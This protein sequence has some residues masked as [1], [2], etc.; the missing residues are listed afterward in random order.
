MVLLNRRLHMPHIPGA[1]KS[2]QNPIRWHLMTMGNAL[3][4]SCT[5]PAM[6]R[7]TI[8]HNWQCEPDSLPYYYF[9]PLLSETSGHSGTHHLDRC[10]ILESEAPVALVH[11]PRVEDHISP[12]LR[13]LLNRMRG[14]TYEP[15]SPNM[16]L[17][18]S[19]QR[20]Q[21]H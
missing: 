11:P 16:G 4:H 7:A 12:A 3:G 14:Q 5:L 17:F 10:A 1:R 18:W 9:Q 21:F 13:R 6:K 8:R 2:H 19:Q 15:N 20:V